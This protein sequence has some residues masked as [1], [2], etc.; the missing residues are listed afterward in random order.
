M[1]PRYQTEAMSRLFSDAKKYQ[2]W[3][4]IEIACLE[5]HGRV[6]EKAD[7]DLV[8]RLKEKSCHINWDEFHK[9][10]VRYEQ[11]THHDVIAFLKALEDE[12]GEDARTL[13][14]GLTSSDIV[15]TGWALIIKEASQRVE[16]NLATLIKTLWGKAQACRGVICLGRTHGQAA[17]PTTFGIKLLSHLMEIV[18]SYERLHQA[19]KGC[20][21]G[22]LSGAVGVYALLEPQIEAEV[23]NTLGL[24]PETVATQVVARDRLAAYVSQ[25]AVLAG[26]IER[27]AVEIRLLMHGEVGEVSEP[28]YEK[29][30]GSSAMPHKKNPIL[31]ENL[32]GLMRLVRSY[33]LASFENQALWHERDISHSSVE[34]VIIPDLFHVLDFAL[35]RCIKLMDGLVVHKECMQQN[36]AEHGD[37]LCSQAVMAALI[38]KGLMRQ[39]AYEVV[40]KAALSTP[41]QFKKAIETD[42]RKHLK[43]EDIEAIF[44]QSYTIRSESVLYDRALAVL[45]QYS[46]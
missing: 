24:V 6:H 32:T 10:V 28:F 42:A 7:A 22:K 27:L 19:R 45:S 43:S 3:L 38:Q 20:L 46:L 39:E 41:A 25:A 36:L 26:S 18:R 11:E 14:L 1:I 13:H 29:Q 8:K 44:S 21:V 4:A 33:A 2:T 5:A 37:I 31:S 40:Q 17:E 15:D 23:L 34:R 16:D 30:K 9:A 35:T 12:F